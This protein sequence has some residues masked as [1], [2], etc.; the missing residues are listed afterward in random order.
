MYVDV[1]ILAVSSVKSSKVLRIF[2]SFNK[3]L[4]FTID[5]EQ[6]NQALY[7]FIHFWATQDNCEF[8]TGT[9][10]PTISGILLNYQSIHLINNKIAS[11]KRT[12]ILQEKY[13]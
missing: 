6:T 3:N 9:E 11:F 13:N 12:H 2:N 5:G 10:K 4:K 8:Q 7:G 1:T